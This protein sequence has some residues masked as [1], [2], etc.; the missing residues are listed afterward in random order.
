MHVPRRV[1]CANPRRVAVAKLIVAVDEADM[2]S[3]H[4][5]CTHASC[6]EP[7]Q[8]DLLHMILLLHAKAVVTI[9]AKPQFSN[10]AQVR[11]PTMLHATHDARST[12]RGSRIM[13]VV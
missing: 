11:N 4:F 3:H 5:T 13:Q 6:S 7:C 1:R 9:H 10:L 8:L 12:Q 2:H